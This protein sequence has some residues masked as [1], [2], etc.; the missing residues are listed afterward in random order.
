MQVMTLLAMQFSLAS[1]YLIHLQIFPSSPC[2]QTPSVC[3]LSLMSETSHEKIIITQIFK[4]F[5]VRAVT[6]EFIIVF[7]RAAIGPYPEAQELIPQ[8]HNLF[9]HFA[10]KFI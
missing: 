8:H 6:Q 10:L 3:V 2:S 1:Y 9:L 5:P 4:K 7:I